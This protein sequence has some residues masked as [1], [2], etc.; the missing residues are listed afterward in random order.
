MVELIAPEGDPLDRIEWDATHRGA[1]RLRAH[2]FGA[3]RRGGRMI[4]LDNDPRARRRAGAAGDGRG[5]HPP[6][7]P[8]GALPGRCAACQRH[9]RA[10]RLALPDRYRGW[11]AA[12][13]RGGRFRCGHVADHARAGQA[14]RRPR[15]ARACRE[16]G[17]GAADGAGASRP[18]DR[19]A[20]R[21]ARRQAAA[22]GDRSLA[23]DGRAGEP[24]GPR[25]HRQD[26][27]CRRQRHQRA[28][29]DGARHARRPVRGLGR[30]QDHA[31]RHDVALCRGG[32]RGGRH[33]RRARPRD[34]RIRRG[35]YRCSAKDAQRDRRLAGR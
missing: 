15:R 3:A 17:P 7:W 31:A 1:G 29:D 26:L 12:R 10:D 4:S 5:H 14:R 34:P 16:P 21:A 28:G 23:A 27:R 35:S 8:G 2:R 6:L 33:D 13:R 32:C 22:G 24:D 20:R 9:P 18:G 11:A 30:R 19:W 25:A